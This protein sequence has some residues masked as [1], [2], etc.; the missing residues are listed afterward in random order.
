MIDRSKSILLKNRFLFEPF[1]V[2]GQALSLAGAELPAE[3]E[4][5]L[6]ERNGENRALLAREM[7]YHH[8]AQG[9]LAGQPYLISF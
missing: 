5:L 7:T 1:Q 4:L 2:T 8:V 6:F 3:T 9:T